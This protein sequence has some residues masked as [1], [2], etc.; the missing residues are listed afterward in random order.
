M[1]I[2]SWFTYVPSVSELLTNE[3][4][5]GTKVRLLPAES[6]A[7]DLREGGDSKFAAVEDLHGNQE[8][9]LKTSLVGPSKSLFN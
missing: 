3:W 7:R 8:W 2:G 1:K 6:L 9:V 4:K 5:T